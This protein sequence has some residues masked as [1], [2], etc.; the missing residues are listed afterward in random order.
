MQEQHELQ[1]KAWVIIATVRCRVAD[2]HSVFLAADD[3]LLLRLL[4]LADQKWSV[5]DC[6]SLD[7]LMSSMLVKLL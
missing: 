3:D 4:S 1:E 2:R 5:V 6:P 7:T